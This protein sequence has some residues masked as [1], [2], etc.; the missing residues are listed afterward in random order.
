MGAVIDALMHVGNILALSPVSTVYSDGKRD[1]VHSLALDFFESDFA[2]KYDA[3]EPFLKVAVPNPDLRLFANVDGD[4]E[5]QNL[6]LFDTDKDIQTKIKRS[7]CEEGNV[8]KCPAIHG[9]LSEVVL[10]KKDLLSHMGAALGSHLLEVKR[11]EANGGDVVFESVKEVVDAFAAKTL[12]PG[13]LKAS[14][15]PLVVTVMAHIRK[16]MNEKDLDTKVLLE[17]KKRQEI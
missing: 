13:D 8:A 5:L 6:N 11:S 10:R 14:L 9:L 17:C 12:H 7:F 2:R 1:D 16:Q 4:P 3:I 15:S